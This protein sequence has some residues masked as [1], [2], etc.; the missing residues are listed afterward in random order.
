MSA[1][2]W[3]EFR[4]DMGP[5][6]HADLYRMRS[7][8]ARQGGPYALLTRDHAFKSEEIGNHD[9]PGAPEIVED[10]CI[11]FTEKYGF[12]LLAAFM[13]STKPCVVKFF[14]GPQGGCIETAVY[15]LY[16]THW[17]HQCSQECNACYD[18]KGIPVAPQRIMKIEF[19]TYRK[20]RRRKMSDDA[21]AASW[22][23]YIEDLFGA[24]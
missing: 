17:G 16:K 21:T 2:E 6:H 12:D 8:N 9:Y 5:N 22:E 1:E 19:P 15:H 7:S 23:K 4:H 20:R 10:I 18:G 3:G 24:V 11:C 13:K 14:D